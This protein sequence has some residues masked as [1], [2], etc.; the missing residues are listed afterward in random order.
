MFRE[1]LK[2]YV[3]LQARCNLAKR[4]RK[5]LE[6]REE[7]KMKGC[8]ERDAK[9]LRLKVAQIDRVIFII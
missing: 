7:K 4:R 3:S 9:G 2:F 1:N 5:K 8:A 6:Q